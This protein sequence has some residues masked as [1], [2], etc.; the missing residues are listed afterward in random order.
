MKKKV[1]ASLKGEKLKES[2]AE[3]MEA[4][5]SGGSKVLQ[6][7]DEGTQEFI[8]MF[9]NKGSKLKDDEISEALKRGNG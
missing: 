1:Q 8:K 2:L 6:K 4:D 9:G 5:P 3:E 7:M